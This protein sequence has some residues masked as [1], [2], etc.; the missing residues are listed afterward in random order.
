MCL[1]GPWGCEGA[2]AKDTQ[3]P[4]RIRNDGV[5]MTEQL[6][7]FGDENTLFNT[8]VQRFLDMDFGGCL[9]T[10]QR[11]HKLFPWGQNARQET[12]MAEFWLTKLG[13]ATWIEIDFAEV[14]RRFRLW[15]EFEEAFGFPWAEES[16][17]RQFQIRYFGRLADG[18][19]ASPKQARRL[20]GGTPVG[21]IH[22]L[23]GRSNPAI[24]LLQALIAAEPADVRAYGYLGDAYALRGD[25]RTARICYREAFALE[26]GAVDVKRLRDPGLREIF[27]EAQ[28]DDDEEPTALEW[29]A[30]RA[31]LSGIF[32]RR[33]LRNMEEAKHWLKRY[34]DLVRAQGKNA[35]EVLA[36]RLFYHAMVL[37]D[38][39]SMLRFNKHVD[40][41]E[42]RRMMK[43]CNPALFARHM[44]EVERRR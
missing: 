33:V 41:A 5:T 14:E 3:L 9:E 19:G 21:L 11:Y 26:P 2:E 37:S 35:D 25:L 38:N 44:R 1:H 6:S 36:P 31:Q 28:G 32:E 39:A 22:L 20:P 23:A 10:L 16:I 17:E 12:A 34:L 40:I 13:G 15:L 18:L 8:G 4:V 42:V 24:A 7:L 27:S 30:V 43:G 29:L